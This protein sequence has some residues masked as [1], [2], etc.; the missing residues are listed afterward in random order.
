MRKTPFGRTLSKTQTPAE[1]AGILDAVPCFEFLDGLQSNQLTYG[2][3]QMS[4]T[5]LGRYK[6]TTLLLLLL[7]LNKGKFPDHINTE[8]YF[9]TIFLNKLWGWGKY[10]LRC[11]SDS[12]SKLLYGYV[13]LLIVHWHLS[14]VFSPRHKRERFVSH[15]R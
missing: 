6:D 8:H 9:L 13:F 2:F 12:V 4:L 5:T 1:A 11:F 14:R 3:Q 10:L 7:L 15:F